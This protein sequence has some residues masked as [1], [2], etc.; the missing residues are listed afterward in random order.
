MAA[1][2]SLVLLALAGF[3]AAE[4]VPIRPIPDLVV[5]GLEGDPSVRWG[6]LDNGLT[7]AVMRND[8]P[9]GKIV[10]R[11]FVGVGAHHELDE[12]QG[13]AHFLE[14]MA[15]N[16]S[17]HFPPGT[18]T[19]TLQEHGIGF[20][21]HSNAHTGAEE[22][23][24]KITLPDT[25]AETI[26]L[27]MQVMS[28]YAGRLLLEEEEIERERGVIQA[29]KR[30]R[31]TAGRRML[32]AL[33]DAIYAGTIAAERDV[34]GTDATIAAI[35]RELMVA[36]YERWYRPDNM[37]FAAVGDVEPARLEAAIRAHFAG[38]EPSGEPL[39][40]VDGG[41]LSP[42]GLQVVAHHEDEATG[43]TVRISNTVAAP[44]P[45]DS[46]A[47]RRE[48]LRLRIADHVLGSRLDR[49]ARKDEGAPITGGNLYAGH[50]YGM[51]VA[52]A[53]V[54]VKAPGR[55]HEAA[56]LVRRELRRF[57][58]F[59]PTDHE[60]RR[61]RKAIEASLEASVN[62]AKSRT[63]ARLSGALYSSWR[64]GE[65]FMTPETRRELYTGM[66]PGITGSEVRDAVA[67][68][69]GPGHR[70][71]SAI[72]KLPDG[73][74]IG[75]ALAAA[76][77]RVHDE[78][79]T[80]PEERRAVEWAYAAEGDAAPE[81]EDLG[82]AGEEVHHLR[83]P[84]N[85]VVNFMRRDRQP[86]EVLIGAR[87]RIAPGEPGWQGFAARGLPESGLDAHDASDLEEL[88]EARRLRLAGPSFDELHAVYR[89]RC[90]SDE[91]PFTCELLR[92]H[93]LHPGWRGDAFERV[94]QRWLQ[95][96][97][98]TMRDPS[99]RLGREFA[100]LVHA[101]TSLPA[102]PSTR[103]V[104]EVAMDDVRGW[105]EPALRGGTLEIGI[106]GDTTL[107][108]VRAVAGRIFG[109]MPERT[110]VARIDDL[111]RDGALAAADPIPAAE[112]VVPLAS[113]SERA[114]LRLAWATD[115]AG[116]I[117][118]ARRL[119][120]LG[121]VVDEKLREVVR[122]EL[123]A[124]YSPYA[125]HRGSTEIDGFGYLAVHAEVEPGQRSAIR[126]VID[127][128]VAALVEEGVDADLL[129]R[130]RKPVLASLGPYREGNGYW[131]DSVVLRSWS[132]PQRLAWKNHMVE[133][134]ASITAE[135][136]GELARRFLASAPR[137][138][139]VVVSERD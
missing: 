80:A 1:I 71:L 64:D 2:R 38:L 77:N 67:E 117:G 133:D 101:G 45:V 55:I 121:K 90:Q 115:D 58:A 89:G 111:D 11:L 17:E 119:S 56:A 129:E 15:F 39:P 107:E 57:V 100:T 103:R 82:V 92:A 36:F 12:E 85:V 32:D 74:G 78:V 16:G 108:A 127:G 7:Y 128:I 86:N 109:T 137:I 122:E 50:H 6:V 113:E 3:L 9:S 91:L 102:P 75:D 93:L 98:G 65:V 120:M 21:S 34:I 54:T 4:H 132:E 24:Y 94:R 72:G 70:V 84:N 29:E 48:G 44:R 27:G 10:M 52:L 114:L 136:I 41:S 66:L 60:M 62:A 59:G 23:V 138:D 35:D 87:V 19:E 46:P 95:A 123:G 33:L 76:W 125:F 13:L 22:T 26:A 124:A 134:Y 126:E 131:L 37:M 79:A 81:P 30:D 63:S 61:A 96:I 104:R 20:G 118:R 139:L 43:T 51:R 73:D 99:G 18:L 28:D 14:H 68:R 40:E 83:Y 135:E 5:P 42:R 49:I 110:E 53:S 97:E 116:D 105:L 88:L 130:V 25:G 31:D 8:Q 69:F 106:V 47:T 112:Q